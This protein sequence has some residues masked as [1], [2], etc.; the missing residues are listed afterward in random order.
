MSISVFN[1]S[2]LQTSPSDINA[3]SIRTRSADTDL[4][5][6]TFNLI[7]G[8]TFPTIIGTGIDPSA[9]FSENCQYFDVNPVSGSGWL[10]STM[11]SIE[12]GVRSN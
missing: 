5:G 2:N 4:V 7:E 10:T 1:F 8:A 9:T 11:D 6:T 12:I 3:I